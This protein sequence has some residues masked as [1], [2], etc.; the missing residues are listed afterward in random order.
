MTI[1]ASLR[2]LYSIVEHAE[3]NMTAHY[4]KLRR[5]THEILEPA[6]FG[7][8]TS[9]ITDDFL[10]TLILLNVLAVT[11]E[12][13]TTIEARFA[14]YFYLFEICSI[15]VFSFEYVIRIWTA[16][17]KYQNDDPTAGGA[18]KGFK[19]IF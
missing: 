2:V 15:A 16:A 4:S 7:D 6:K 17:I 19:Y 11:L 5:R 3:R 13:I 8:K 18:K 1:R 9:K 12:S 14:S 10:T